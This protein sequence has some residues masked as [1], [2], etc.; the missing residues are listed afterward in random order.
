MPYGF[1]FSG[2]NWWRV[3]GFNIYLSAVLEGDSPPQAESRTMGPGT[4]PF[5]YTALSSA[6]YSTNPLRAIAL[7]NN[8]I[9]P[10]IKS[11]PS[12]CLL[13]LCSSSFVNI[14]LFTYAGSQFRLLSVIKAIIPPVHV[15]FARTK[16]SNSPP[17]L[18]TVEPYLSVCMLEH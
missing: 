13:P 18:Q 9:N 6:S 11:I 1:R 3:T 15:S 7:Y 16:V 14:S 17:C 8:H 12:S 5:G 2:S 10:Y 4:H